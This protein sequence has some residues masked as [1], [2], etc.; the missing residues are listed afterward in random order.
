MLPFRVLIVDLSLCERLVAVRDCLIYFLQIFYCFMLNTCFL[1]IE[2]HYQKIRCIGSVIASMQRMG[3][4][5]DSVRMDFVRCLFSWDFLQC[6]QQQ[7]PEWLGCCNLET[8]CSCVRA[9]D[10]RAEADNVEMRILAEDNG[11]LK[12]SMVNLYDSLLAVELF[13]NL[14]QEV[15]DFAVWVRIPTAIASAQFCLHAHHVETALD[16]IDN[17]V[18]HVLT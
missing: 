6:L 14:L 2:S 15:Q 4:Y 17:V 9:A 5:S 7:V 18:F 3:C 11:A 13:V 8:L 1:C 16:L 10:G 12:A